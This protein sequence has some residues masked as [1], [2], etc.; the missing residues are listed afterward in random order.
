MTA[1]EI[2]ADMRAFTG[3]GVISAAELE[4][5]KTNEIGEEARKCIMLESA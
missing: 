2:A 5:M 4:D 3:A 1:S